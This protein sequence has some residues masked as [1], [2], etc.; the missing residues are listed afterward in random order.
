M[1][2]ILLEAFNNE[3]NIN[4]HKVEYVVVDKETG[5]IRGTGSTDR[6][7]FV[8]STAPEGC[9]LRE[10]RPQDRDKLS[11]E[12]IDWDGKTGYMWKYN[13]D[14]H[15]LEL[16]KDCELCPDTGVPRRVNKQEL[17]GK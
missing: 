2:Q 1:N 10:V 3:L 6:K 17:K 14:K 12:N 9:E 5:E 7:A 15:C 13:R 8:A 4:P 16:R 11:G